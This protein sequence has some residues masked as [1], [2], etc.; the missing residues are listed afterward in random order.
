MEALRPLSFGYEEFFRFGGGRH[1]S[2]GQALTTR[3]AGGTLAV[4]AD[5]RDLREIDRALGTL[6]TGALAATLVLGVASAA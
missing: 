5:R 3:L 6:F 1:R 4:V 2:V